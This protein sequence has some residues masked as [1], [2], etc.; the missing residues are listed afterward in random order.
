M[1]TEIQNILSF[2]TKEENKKPK[3][4]ISYAIKYNEINFRNLLNNLQTLGKNFFYWTHAQ[5]E[6][7]F[8]EIDNTVTIVSVDII[9][10]SDVLNTIGNIKDNF[11]NNWSSCGLTSIPFVFGAKKFLNDK[12]DFI[13]SD[14][15][16]SYWF[17]PKYIFLTRTGSSFLILNFF[18]N[19]SNRQSIECLIKEATA[20]NSNHKSS[21]NN[22]L[23]I[24]IHEN[25]S[26][27][28][29]WYSSI[30]QALDAISKKKFLKAVLSRQVKIKLKN[31]PSLFCLMK[32][33]L[34]N[35]PNCYIFM[36]KLGDSIFF[37]ASPETLVKISNKLIEIDA[38][39]GSIERGISKKDDEELANKLL[40]S[41]KDLT[42]HKLVLK[43]IIDTIS[44]FAYEINYKSSPKI[45]KLGNIQHLWTPVR[46]KLKSN[47]PLFTISNKLH[48]T[49]A[50][51]GFPR[52]EALEF[53]NYN[54]KHDR[55]LFS[56]YI[57]WF[58]FQ[59]ECEFAV[60]IRSALIKDNYLYVF[61]G[62]GIVEGSNAADE[63]EE[64]NLKMQPILSL[65]EN[66][67]TH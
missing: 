40:Q 22:D 20:L 44:N 2:L 48:P 61:S 46:A 19:G 51:C 25:E 26:D 53:L 30:E 64:S 65:F 17:I 32:N 4:L 3:Q 23:K 27:Y 13:W 24:T 38:L 60:G 7:H 1:I 41:E 45:K 43:Y 42:E 47:I 37:G 34:E 5:N 66:E 57:G 62:C 63:Y 12:K 52:K 56:G 28:L 6:Q 36:Y 15:S 14:Y 21:S 10:S 18:N 33:L 39:A 29:T 11:R 16:D 58:N 50:V 8:C 67:N 31:Q 54:E 55:G 59:N 49:P 9:Q 35:N